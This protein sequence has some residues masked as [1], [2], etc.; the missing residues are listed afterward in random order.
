[1][2]FLASGVLGVEGG[3]QY[4]SLKVGGGDEGRGGGGVAGW[5]SGVGGGGGRSGF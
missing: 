1:M 3:E 2:Q 4:G 5:G